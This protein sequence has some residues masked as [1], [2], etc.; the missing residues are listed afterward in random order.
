[1]QLPTGQEITPR[2][3]TISV[4]KSTI[5][6]TGQITQAPHDTIRVELLELAGESATVRVT[7]PSQTTITSPARYADVAATAMRILANG[8]TELTRL[9][10]GKRR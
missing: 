7:W 5:L 2:K 9:K 6:A 4:S 3:E 1:V 10:A 8:S